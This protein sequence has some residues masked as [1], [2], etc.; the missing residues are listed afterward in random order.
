[1]TRLRIALAACA[2]GLALAACVEETPAPEDATPTRTPAPASSTVPVTPTAVS[3]IAPIEFVTFRHKSGVFS[4]SQPKDWEIVDEST[5][6]KLL[7]RFI[8]PP[9]FGSRVTVEVTNEGVLTPEQIHNKAE[10]V[11]A[12]NFTPN[13]AYQET[14]RSGLPDGRFQV[15]YDYDDRHGGSGKETLTFQQVGPFLVV[16]RIFLAT[17]DHDSLSAALDKMAGSLIIDPQA[18]WGTTVAAINPAELLIAN[19]LLWS[20]GTTVFYMGEIYNASPA[21]AANVKVQVTLCDKDGVALAPL[22]AEVGLKVIGRGTT[23]PFMVSMQKLPRGVKI[24]SEQASGDPAK[25]DPT[26]TTAINL[27]VKPFINNRGRLEL[28]G[29]AT[30]PGLSPV[31]NIHVVLVVYNADN[32]VVGYGSLTSDADVLLAP[33]QA[34]PVGYTF[35]SLGAKADHYLALAEAEVV[36]ASNP[37]LNP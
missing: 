15:T 28:N 22:T 13:Q 14:S 37:S 4:I 12:L 27:D 9:G 35:E 2:V 34:W 1:M 20:D 21:E 3:V 29:Q 6:Q 10:S 31:K 5:D 17:P 30:N 25:P 24:C 32:K 11:I 7:V 26:Y 16:V 19:T 8:P 23:V 36:S 33:G 18:A